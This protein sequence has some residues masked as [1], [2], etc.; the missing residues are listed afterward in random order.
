MDG[1]AATGF[2]TE[3]GGQPSEV[4]AFSSAL[5]KLSGLLN[6]PSHHR[7]GKAPSLENR[8]EAAALVQGILSN[9]QT[10]MGDLPWHMEAN[11]VYGQQP[12]V[13]S[14]EAWSHGCP[15]PR[16]LRVIVWTGA[17][18]GIHV[19]FWNKERRNPVVPDPVFITRPGERL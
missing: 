2:L 18:P 1:A 10:F 8:D 14:G 12:K 17:S 16:L 11:F 5:S 3:N 4:Q 6:P 15:P 7:E 19:K 9:A 13:L